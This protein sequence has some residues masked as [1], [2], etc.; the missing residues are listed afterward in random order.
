MSGALA[1]LRVVEF[2]QNAAIPQCGRLLAGLG[3]DVVKVEPPEGDA[4]R[5]LAGLAEN[6]SRAYAVINPG[7]RS[8]A[9]DLAADGARDAVNALFAWADVALVAFKLTDLERYGIAWDQAKQVNPALIHVT[10]TALG[11]DGPDA[12][13][14]GYEVLAQGRSGVGYIINRSGDSGPLPSRPAVTDFG[15]GFSAAFA[16]LAALRHR[17]RTGEGQRI[18]TSLLGTAMSLGTP[19]FGEFAGDDERLAELEADIGAVRHAGL[20]FDVE[21]SIYESKVQAGGGAF[22]LYFRHYQTLD[23]LISLAGLSPGLVAKFHEV[24]GL[25][26]PTSNDVTNPGFTDVV[27]RAEALF[28]QR[29]TDEWLVALREVGYP[30]GPY[31]MPHQAMHDPH[32]LANGY[33]VELDHPIFGPYTTVGMPFQMEKST[34]EISGPSPSLAA[35]TVQVMTEAGIDP[36]LIDQL[37]ASGALVQRDG[38]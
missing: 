2:A 36:A 3:A 15:S 12:H 11:P 26:R 20:G 23:G 9:I 1:D 4:M 34:S 35:H 29:T 28:A 24:T 38:D 37:V 22:R 10:H 5:R 31:N 30:C 13:Y 32:V 33:A 18:D 25:D 27:D 7:K 19:L 6:E 14:G 8:I 16:V 17:D 21:R